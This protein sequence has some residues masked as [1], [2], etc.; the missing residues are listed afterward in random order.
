MGC[1]RVFAWL[2][3]EHLGHLDHLCHALVDGGSGR[4]FFLRAEH[5]AE[6]CLGLMNEFVHHGAVQ[7]TNA[8]NTHEPRLARREHPAVSVHV[9]IEAHLNEE[10]C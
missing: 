2:V 6:L 10:T 7:A 3:L 1:S 9:W 8:V 5:A 4:V